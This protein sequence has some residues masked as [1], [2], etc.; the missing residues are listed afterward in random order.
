M[1]RNP[2]AKQAEG[3]G[4]KSYVLEQLI[5]QCR[6][7]GHPHAEA[8]G[9]I[10]D[11]RQWRLTS[12]VVTAGRG[13]YKHRGISLNQTPTSLTFKGGTQEHREKS[14]ATRIPLAAVP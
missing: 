4:G 10:L 2:R 7:L 11:V 14:T 3:D 1:R 9:S 12:E 8:Q 6:A 13:F 5:N